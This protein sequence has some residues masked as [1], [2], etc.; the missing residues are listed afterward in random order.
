MITPAGSRPTPGKAYPARP[1]AGRVDQPAG[2]AGSRLSSH[3][4][5]RASPPADRPPPVPAGRP[6]A[7]VFSGR[8]FT[9]RAQCVPRSMGVFAAGTFRPVRVRNLIAR[10]AGHDESRNNYIPF[11]YP[12]SSRARDAR[13]PVPVRPWPASSPRYQRRNGLATNFSESGAI[14]RRKTDKTRIFLNPGNAL[15]SR[16]YVDSPGA[17]QR[18]SMEV[19]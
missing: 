10:T 15:T 5:S 17:A 1:P 19:D 16:V 18:T 14:P 11:R 3:R 7:L 4:T 2:R 12:A 9:T 13:P 6:T 8:K